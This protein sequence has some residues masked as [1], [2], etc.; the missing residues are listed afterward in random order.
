MV[1]LPFVFPF[2]FPTLSFFSHYLGN[3]FPVL[4]CSCSPRKFLVSVPSTLSSFRI[5][6]LRACAYYSWKKNLRLD[7]SW[8]SYSSTFLFNLWKYLVHLYHKGFIIQ[9]WIFW[10]RNLVWTAI[11]Q[12]KIATFSVSTFSNNLFT[13]YI[14]QIA[15]VIFLQKI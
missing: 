2:M 13:L 3:G 9:Y 12:R 14:Y 6:W 15:T 4:L 1:Q 8:Y 7:H 5:S 11:F 10:S